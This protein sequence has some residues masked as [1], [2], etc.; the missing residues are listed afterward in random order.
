VA[1]CRIAVMLSPP[2]TSVAHAVN[3]KMTG[4]G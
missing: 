4:S 1:H 3:V 2:T